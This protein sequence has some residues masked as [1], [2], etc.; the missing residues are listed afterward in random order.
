MIKIFITTNSVFV[1][2]AKPDVSRA[3]KLFYC[4]KLEKN[5][6]IYNFFK[7]G[8][9]ENLFWGLSSGFQGKFEFKTHV[10]L[11]PLAKTPNDTCF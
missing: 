6:S 9:M 5:L 8:W 10:L 1:W 3:L 7:D 2:S 11:P 4:C